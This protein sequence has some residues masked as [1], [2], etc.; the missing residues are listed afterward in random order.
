MVKYL[1]KGQDLTEV[2]GQKTY[3]VDFYADWCGPCKMLSPILDEIDFID[4]LK[5]NVDEHQDVAQSYGVMSIPTLL[6]FKDGLE[7]RKEIGFKNKDEIKR[8][9]DEL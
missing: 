4:V 5:I 8:I 1:E 3:L 7:K 9:V 2:I 6:F